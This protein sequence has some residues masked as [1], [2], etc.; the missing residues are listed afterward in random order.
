MKSTPTQPPASFRAD[1]SWKIGIVCSSFYKEVMEQLLEAAL[2]ALQSGG[3][4]EKNITV[5]WAPGCFEIPLIGKA[6]AQ[7]KKVDG[8]IALGIIVEGET[9]HA[10]LLAEQASRG[11]MDVQLAYQLPFA[12]EILYVPR[13]EQARERAAG[14]HNKGAEA[15]V[16]VLQSLQVLKGIRG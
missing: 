4:L 10:R 5:H 12:F 3:I 1:P 15:A 14:S 7:E 2:S 8:L 16:A 11:I 9:H 13:F 6:L